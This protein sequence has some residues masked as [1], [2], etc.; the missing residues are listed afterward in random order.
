MTNRLRHALLMPVS[1]A[2][3]VACGAPTPEGE[4]T[5]APAMVPAGATTDDAPPATP[6]PE[7]ATPIPATAPHHGGHGHA[8][9]IDCPLKA[10]G[11]DPA[12][13]QPFEDSAAYIAF[14]E[15]EDRA[16]WQKPDAL[17]AALELPLDAVVVD[18]G[19][20]SGYF[21]FRFAA[22]LPGG[23]V[24]ALDVSPEM[25]RHVHHKMMTDG[26]ANLRA[27]V[28]DKDAPKFRDD[29]D[30]VFVCDV[31]HHV[32]DAS[33][34]LRGVARQ[35]K[36]G[37]R[38]ALVE[39]KEG[40]LPEGPPEALKIPKDRLLALGAEAGLALARDH[41]GLLPYQELLVFE[42]KAP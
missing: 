37:A 4:A 21:A 11:H 6:S 24:E 29:A 33:G 3:I 12:A 22:A 5:P 32:G 35:M 1:A 27:G 7:P 28:V 14:L 38:L 17:I 20:G 16:S 39:F 31:L 15:K 41:S 13:L 9:P 25:V 10:A 36:A 18:L 19:A 42:K 26:T 40:E 34:W 23:H 8:A 30:L 2:A